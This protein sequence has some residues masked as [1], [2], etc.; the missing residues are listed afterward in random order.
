MKTM[1]Q[2]KHLTQDQQKAHSNKD[3]FNI[4]FLDIDRED[5]GEYLYP[6]SY[7]TFGHPVLRNQDP[8]AVNLHI[9]PQA[10]AIPNEDVSPDPEMSRVDNSAPPSRD[11]TQLSSP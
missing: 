1:K 9:S 2:I 4:K 10:Q 3:Y 8:E 7:W 6:G 11:I 5:E